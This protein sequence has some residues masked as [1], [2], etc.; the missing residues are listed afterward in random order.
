ML[1]DQTGSLWVSLFDEQSEKLVGVPA[2]QVVELMEAN[3]EAEVDRIFMEAQFKTFTFRLIAKKDEYQGRAKLK[4]T[5]VSLMPDSVET[6][7]ELAAKLA[8]YGVQ[9]DVTNVDS[10]TALLPQTA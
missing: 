7:K 8:E 6:H 5:C 4:T 10:L 3:K 2:K 1:L 9:V